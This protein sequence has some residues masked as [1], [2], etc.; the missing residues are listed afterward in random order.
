MGLSILSGS[1]LELI[2]EVL[3]LMKEKGLEKVPVVVG[4]II[5][6]SDAK[7]LREKG[8]ARVY[9]P[10]DFELNNIMSEMVDVAIAAR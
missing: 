9:T 8:V 3:R 4:G 7:M 5:P 2:P 10:K 1:H 6:D